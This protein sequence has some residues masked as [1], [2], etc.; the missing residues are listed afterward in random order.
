MNLI[1]FIIN[2]LAGYDVSSKRKELESIISASHVG[3]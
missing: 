2:K 1:Q 3:S